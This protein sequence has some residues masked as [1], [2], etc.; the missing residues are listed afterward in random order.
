MYIHYITPFYIRN[1]NIYRFGICR[2]FQK[3]IPCKYQGM[4][5]LEIQRQR[6]NAINHLRENQFLLRILRN[7]TLN[8]QPKYLS[9]SKKYFLL[10]TFSGRLLQETPWKKGSNPRQGILENRNPVKRAKE[11][12]FNEDRRV[13]VN[14]SIAG[15][16]ISSSISEHGSRLQE[17]LFQANA[18]D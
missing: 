9:R 7:P 14:N 17:R 12:L 6:S 13:E 10:W 1:L 8:F 2:G 11:N 15:L 4:T 5:I 16:V 3:P 18:I